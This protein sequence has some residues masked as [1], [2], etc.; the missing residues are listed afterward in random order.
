MGPGAALA[1]GHPLDEGTW[2][3]KGRTGD[4]QR[5]VVGAVFVF[6]GKQH[7]SVLSNVQGKRGATVLPGGKELRAIPDEVR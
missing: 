7:K 2:P 5:Q 1:S 4:L 6:L 3:A